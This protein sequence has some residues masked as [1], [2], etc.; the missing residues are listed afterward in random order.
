VKDALGKARLKI[1]L[2]AAS[3]MGFFDPTAIV[4]IDDEMIPLL[5]KWR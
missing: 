4:V 2:T 5:L 1:D 3:L